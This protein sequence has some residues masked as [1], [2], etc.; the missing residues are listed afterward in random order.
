[1]GN[2]KQNR[3]LKLHCNNTLTY[4]KRDKYFSGLLHLTSLT[5]VG[6]DQEEPYIFFI[7]V[8]V[9]ENGLRTY[10]FEDLN[11]NTDNVKQWI[12]ILEGMIQKLTTNV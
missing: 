11:K 6:I 7:K 3:L 9:P 5:Q 8:E 1:M 4:W 10:Q 12:T 2:A